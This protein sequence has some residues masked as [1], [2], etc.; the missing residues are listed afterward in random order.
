MEMSAKPSE[1]KGHGRW[2]PK[3]GRTES[4]RVLSAVRRCSEVKV[5]LGNEHWQREVSY[6]ARIIL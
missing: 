1:K 4:R 3:V 5:F 2:A 6:K